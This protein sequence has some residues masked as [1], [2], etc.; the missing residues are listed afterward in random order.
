MSSSLF[1]LAPCFLGCSR[2]VA[3][4]SFREERGGVAFDP[5][6]LRA[7]IDISRL[8]LKVFW[9]IFFNVRK[10]LWEQDL[11]LLF[12]QESSLRPEVLTT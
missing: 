4:E 11:K 10:P 1:R 7:R 2:G 12:F 5:F 6:I 9:I 8:F 3:R